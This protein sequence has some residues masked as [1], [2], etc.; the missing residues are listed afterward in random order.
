[1]SVKIGVGKFTVNIEGLPQRLRDDY[2]KALNDGSSLNLQNFTV[3]D[4]I[5]TSS[6][7]PKPIGDLEIVKIEDTVVTTVPVPEE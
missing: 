1:M 2:D 6:N 7:S 5:Y 3:G 4:R